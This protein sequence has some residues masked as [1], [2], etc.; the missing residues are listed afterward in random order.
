MPKYH[1]YNPLAKRV[2]I[3]TPAGTDIT[4]ENHHSRPML[5]HSG[6]VPVGTYEMLPGQISWTPKLETING[7]IIFDGSV[8]PPIGLLKEPIRLKIAQGRITKIEGGAEGRSFENWLASFDDPNM[9]QLAHISYG[10][11][12]GAILTGNVVENERVWGATEWG[13]DNQK[14]G[15][16]I[17]RLS[18]G[19]K[20]SC[21]I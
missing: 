13:I 1:N 15:S 16:S 19:V 10:F 21:H 17:R 2:R 12:P 4:F 5:I 20:K 11:N 6:K 7:T 3:T 8:T 9:Y 14:R 18:R